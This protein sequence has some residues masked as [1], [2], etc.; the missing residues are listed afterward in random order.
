MKDLTIHHAKE[1]RV[2]NVDFQ[3]LPFGKIISDH[4]F[5]ID[6]DGK[7]WVN[8]RISP[9]EKMSIHPMNMALH[10][11]Q[12]IFE[13][14]KASRSKD[15]T[16]LLFRPELH[17]KRMNAS[18]VRMC[19][20]EIPEDIFVE[21]IH[22]IV[23]IDQEW[24]PKIEGSAMYIRPLM[25]ATDEMVGVKA[26]DTYKFMI[27]CLPVGPYYPKPIKLLVEPH[28]IRAAQGG[29]GE[30]KTAGNYAAALYPSKLAR[31]QGYDQVLWLDAVHHKFVQE[32]GTMNIFFVF[33]NEIVTPATSGTILKG[34]TRASTL[35]ILRGNGHTVNERD[36]SIDEVLSRYQAGELIEVFGTGTA[37]LIANVEEIK[38]DNHF[39]RLDSSNWALS[40]SIKD[41]INGMRFGTIE[42]KRGWTVPVKEVAVTA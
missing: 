40:T 16:P 26:S 6:Y 34:I 35:E 3:N 32:V 20:P 29:V 24:I 22:A 17:A 4:M 31:E 18:A 38:Y 39:I 33:N 12:S 10:Y 41:E 23:G 28:Y 37:A 42:D 30:A 7:Q 36:L 1:S 19:M 15:G 5:E 8:P 14:M 27:I 13:G 25:F 9:V 11:G 21:A 2:A